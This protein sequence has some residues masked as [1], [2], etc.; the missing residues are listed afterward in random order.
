MSGACIA[1]YIIILSGLH[2]SVSSLL[3]QTVRYE[4]VSNL[5]L[6]P[7]SKGPLPFKYGES[8]LVTFNYTFVY[9]NVTIYPKRGWIVTVTIDNEK[10]AAIK[11]H[12]TFYIDKK[13]L[14]GNITIEVSGA[15]A[16][17]SHLR[18]HVQDWLLIPLAQSGLSPNSLQQGQQVY[19]DLS[20]QIFVTMANRP[21][22]NLFNIVV[23][24]LVLT[25]NISMGTQVDLQ[26]VKDQLLR[27]VAAS[28]GLFSQFVF[29]PL[30]A[31]VV[32][33]NLDVDTGIKL[34]L[35][36]CGCAP[37]GLASN[38]FTYLLH[39]NVSLSITMTLCSTL[40]S[41]GLLPLWFF[42]IGEYLY[43][44][45]EIKIPFLNILISL[46]IIVIP[47]V[48]G[49]FLQIKMPSIARVII[50]TTRLVL[51][52]FLA[53]FLTVGTYAN[54]W[55][56]GM[57]DGKILFASGALPY[58]GFVLGGF[59][60]FVGRQSNS[61]IVTIAVETGIQNTAV[62]I[63]LLRM[64]LTGPE[65]ATSI[66]VP[67]ISSTLTPLP[68]LVAILYVEVKDCLQNRGKAAEELASPEDTAAEEEVEIGRNKPPSRHS[69]HS[70]VDDAT[71]P[72]DS[73]IEGETRV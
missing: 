9:R 50:K 19:S 52:I 56:L 2:K 34:G 13:N 39:G 10:V 65:Q 42:T 35:F 72:S 21:I 59:A 61:D 43:D 23:F 67:L 51:G 45:S 18:F 57:V 27:P 71:F 12:D 55:V 60:A 63:V 36:A 44:K 47:T 64:S 25:A 8:S 20:F 32:A 48:I 15:N 69:Q 17:R 31:F 16:G 66:V 46:F 53:F 28:I 54:W 41:F 38:I 11:G 3:N 30:I 49:L 29:M 1:F 7:A 68:L 37:G 22:D 73:F 62:P 40:A 5:I 6:T 58:F 70:R 14:T 24:L 33:I 26:I 4:T